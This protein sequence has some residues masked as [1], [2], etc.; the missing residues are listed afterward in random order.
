M[1]AT[2]KNFE[3]LKTRYLY[4]YPAYFFSSE[5][6]DVVK[7]VQ[8]RLRN[9]SVTELRRQLV[10]GGNEAQQ[11]PPV[12]RLDADTLQRLEEMLVLPPSERG[13]SNKRL[14]RMQFPNDMPVTFHFFGVIPGRDPTDAESWAI[15]ALLALLLPLCLD[16]KVVASES[17]VPILS[18]S[19]GMRETV[20][21]DSPH[22]FVSDL[23]NTTRINIDQVQPTLARLLSA[24]FI[25]LDANSKEGGNDFYQWGRIPP[26]ARNLMQSPL[27]AFAYLKKWERKDT[28]NN[29]ISPSKA[30]IYL[31]Y[32]EYFEQGEQ[33]MTIPREL[34]VRYRAFYRAK[35]F[36]SNSTLRP[37]AIASKALLNADQH[38]FGDP[39]SL[40]AL[41]RG[42]LSAFMSRVLSGSADGYSVK[43]QKGAERDAAIQSFAEY[44]VN[45]VFMAAFRGDRAALRGKQLNLI[46][47]ACEVIYRDL[48]ARE[49]A[50]G[51]VEDDQ[52]VVTTDEL[53]EPE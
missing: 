6:L 12:V 44:F 37:L 16:V 4:L 14:L 23:T 48:Q 9:I 47:N 41:V 39:E 8:E 30:Q 1:N 40:V 11:Q 49:R 50:A 36:N 17:L 31:R 27:F 20:L 7:D 26:V 46:K 45:N 29:A 32:A 22:A 35:R 2:G 24:Y 34:T 21:L 42:E 52:A 15:P 5:T 13:G 38:A 3:G 25:H 51:V 18:E 28:K 33:D 10:D 19:D 43:G 53:A